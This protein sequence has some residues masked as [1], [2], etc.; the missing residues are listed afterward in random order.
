M[1]LVCYERVFYEQDEQVCYERVLFLVVCYE[2][3]SFE[4]T[5]FVP[6]PTVPLH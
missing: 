5:P 1:N 4:R 2:Q 6:P 3:V